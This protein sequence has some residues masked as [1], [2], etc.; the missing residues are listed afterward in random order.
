MRCKIIFF[1]LFVI[2][3]SLLFA[4]KTT[5]IIPENCRIIEPAIENIDV[6]KPESNLSGKSKGIVDTLLYDD[7]SPYG[8]HQGNSGALYW[9]VKFSPSEPCTI[10]AGLITTWTVD[11]VPPPN[12]SLL[13]WSDN[14]GQPGNLV[15]GPFAFAATGDVWAWQKVDATTP[16]VTS[17]DFWLG[18]WLPWYDKP[19]YG[20]TTFAMVDAAS[21][22]GDRQGLSSDRTT[23]SINSGLKDL[24]I[25]AVVAYS[26]SGDAEI[27]VTP[28]SILLSIDSTGGS[29]MQTK[30]EPVSYEESWKSAMYWE[31]VKKGE[32]I[33]GYHKNILDVHKVSLKELGITSKE[34]TIISKG[35]SSL[36]FVLF[37]VPGD[38]PEM[39]DFMRLMLK[40]PNVRYVEPNKGDPLFF[41]P[42]DTYWGQQWGPE[43]LNCPNAW[44]LGLGS[45]DISVA[46]IDVGVDY[47]HEDL[48]D[49]FTSVLGWDFH[50]NDAYPMP[51]TAGY[52]FHGTHAAGAAAAC[53]NNNKGIAGVAN[54]QLYGLKC[55]ELLI[56]RVHSTNAIQWCADNG[57]DVISMSF[58]GPTQSTARHDACI[59][60]WDSGCILLAATGNGATSTPMYPSAHSEVIA[61]GSVDDNDVKAPNSNWGSHMELIG[62]GVSI[63]SCVLSN[64]YASYSGTSF[65]CP[66]VAGGFALVKASFPDITNQNLR[67]LI[68]TTAIDLGTSGWDNLYGYGKP[69]LF[70]ALSGATP[71][72]A[73]TGVLNVSNKSSASGDLYVSGITWKSSWVKSVEPK[74][75]SLTPGNSRN[76]TVIAGAKLSTGYYYDTLSIA[77][78][79][80]NDNPYLVPIRLKVGNVGIEEKIN[81]SKKS[82]ALSCC[83]N[84]FHKLTTINYI[85]PNLKPEIQNAT[86]KVLLEVYDVTGSLVKTLINEEQKQGSYKTSWDTKSSDKTSR[87]PG[88]IYFVKCT[89]DNYE[90]TEK[91]I[92]IK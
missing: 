72:P 68:K 24:L 34:I 27:E 83:P 86:S 29:K 18:Y 20:D 2:P 57:V 81:I 62:P 59:A 28:T 11:G 6:L 25:R 58:G 33:V 91:I 35:F 65:A 53:I 14:A 54:A 15:A 63:L 70:A 36:N 49:H 3:C 77:S 73:D 55:G 66:A 8:G 52:P 56:D 69:D 1:A 40:N 82:I 37:D 21:N 38:I 30:V 45:M 79:D 47:T 26:G 75:F 13:V 78:N 87:I 5:L 31:N 7:G 39:K 4:Q 85:V 12:C 43:A 84:P 61:V 90:A 16:Y 23:W 71:V 64:G 41:T 76:V 44:D 60:A 51:G 92:V 10:K 22:H 48:Q 42:N 9:A 19:A 50:G 74:N 46:I 32:V 17:S 88:G 89:I 80:P 67:D